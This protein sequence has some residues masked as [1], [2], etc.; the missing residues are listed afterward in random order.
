[1]RSIAS[2][3][4]ALRRGLWLEEESWFSTIT[5]SQLQIIWLMS[6]P[7]CL[8]CT[9][10]SSTLSS[11]LTPN[12]SKSGMPPPVLSKA[13]LEIWPKKKSP[14]FVWMRERESSS[15]ATLGEG[16]FRSISKMEL[17]WRSSRREKSQRIKTKMI[18]LV[19][20]IGE[21]RLFC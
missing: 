19:C 15:W 21:T 4:Q 3:S 20:T 12:A 7:L 2:P 1:M 13:S 11:L 16:C 18:F 5:M 14:A 8:F 10:L 17:K 9:T 6:K